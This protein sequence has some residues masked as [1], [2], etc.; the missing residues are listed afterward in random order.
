[1]DTPPLMNRLTA[2]A[3]GTFGFFFLGFSGIAAAV[4]QPGSITSGGIAAG[5]G[6]G[7]GLMIF[8]FGHISGGHYN[9]AVTLGLAVGGKFPMAEVVPYWVAQLV[10]GL[11]A[12]V[13]ARIV[14]TGSAADALVNTPV[15][16]KGSAIVLEF[17][18]T[19]LFVLVIF[20]V[21]T[22]ATAPWKGVLAPVAIGGFIFIAAT[23]IG[24]ATGG[25]FN[26]ARSLAPAIVQLKL[27]DVWIYLLAPL[28]GGALA[29]YVRPLLFPVAEPQVPPG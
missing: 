7:L 29:G 15:V 18:A 12:A 3:V 22:D 11:V 20:T 17:V 19:F 26:P 27:T 13:I 10:G 5:F 25:S 23:V 6:G 14:Y 1:M 2:E 21:A 24:P 4:D 8:A 9:P 16:G 28:A